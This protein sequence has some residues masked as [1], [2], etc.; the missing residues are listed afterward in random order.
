[1]FKSTELGTVTGSSSSFQVAVTGDSSI[2]ARV[3]V[4]KVPGFLEL[5]EAIRGADLAYTHCESLIHDFT[6]PE[7]HPAAEGGWVWMRSPA[8]AA[9]ELKWVGF[10]I[11]SLASNHC[12]DYSYGGL[13]STWAALDAAGLPH[14]GTGANLAEARAPAFID[15]A[16]ARVALISMCSSFPNWTRAGAQRADAAGRP[17]LNPLGF[18]HVLDPDLIEQAVA[19]AIRLGWWVT[20]A[21]R[22]VILNPPGLHNTV[23]RLVQSDQPGL[24]TEVDEDDAR[25]NLR[26]IQEAKRQADFVIAHLHTHEWDPVSNS[27]AVPVDFVPPFARSCIDAGADVFVGQGAHAPLRGIEIYAGKP[28]FYDP[29]DVFEMGRMIPRQPADYYLRRDYDAA[30]REP[31]VTPML[32]RA[33]NRAA[34][35]PLNPPVGYSKEPGIVLPICAFGPDLSLRGISLIPATLMTEPHHHFGIPVRARG[36]AAT[37]ILET[38]Q[39]LSLSFGTEMTIE[40]DVGQVTLG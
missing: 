32:G 26:A 1:M 25:G 33:A 22:D 23:V 27:L 21:G 2:N 29:G 15:T 31:E 10:D 9:E 12:L 7:I 5:V 37:R 35:R 36:A 3:S 18:H 20:R 17:G 30:A 40:D 11:V 24:R 13:Y 4:C 39:R 16:K 38:L 28:I 14:A 8:F 19:T 34:Y 6:G